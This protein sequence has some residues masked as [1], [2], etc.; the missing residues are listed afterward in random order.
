MGEVAYH[1]VRCARTAVVA[2]QVPAKGWF[3]FKGF[4]LQE[5]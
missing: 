3:W 2:A 4:E 1:L 5:L